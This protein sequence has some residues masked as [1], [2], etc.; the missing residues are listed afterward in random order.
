MVT[1]AYSEIE[2]GDLLLPYEE[3]P[4]RFTA[5]PSRQPVDGAVVAQQPHRSY[6]GEGDVIV[7]D[8]G[9]EHGLDVGRELIVYRP[10][11]EVTD[12]LTS[13][14]VLE[15]D[16]RIGRLFV[17]KAGPRTSLALVTQ[18]RTEVAEGDRFRSEP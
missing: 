6:S 18:A 15:P 8:R 7:L 1:D 12:P 9:Q 3:A 16:D 4:E 17:L 14:P 11:H 5:Q 13:V 10:G 2:P